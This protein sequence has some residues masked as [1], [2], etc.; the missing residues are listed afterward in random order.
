MEVT[1]WSENR[2]LM[3]LNCGSTWTYCEANLNECHF[4]TNEIREELRDLGWAVLRKGLCKQPCSGTIFETI[5]M[6][7]SDLWLLG[8]LIKTNT[9]K[10]WVWTLLTLWTTA[11]GQTQKGMNWAYRV[12][13]KLQIQINGEYSKIRSEFCNLTTSLVMGIRKNTHNLIL[14]ILMLILHFTLMC[15]AIDSKQLLI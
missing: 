12:Q 5:I 11:S 14:Q 15:N 2:R 6:F 3:F 13:S 9:S 10:E 1:I 4:L 7:S 8:L